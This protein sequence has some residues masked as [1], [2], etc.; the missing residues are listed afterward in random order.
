M[1]DVANLGYGLAIGIALGLT[2]GGGSIVTL[3]ILVY[4]VGESVH[5]AIT[6][7]LA[8]VGAIAAHGASLQRA[9]VRWKT[10]FVVGACGLL[11][12]FPGSLLSHRLPGNVLLSIFAAVMLLAATAMLRTRRDV[13]GSGEPRSPAAVMTAGFGLGFLT[14]FLGVGGGFLIVPVLVFVLGLSMR[15][16]IATSLFVIALNSA[17]SLAAHAVDGA[18]DGRTAVLFVLGGIGGNVV[19]L[20]VGKRL[21]QQRLKQIFATLV[22]GIGLLTGAGAVGILPF[23]VR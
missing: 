13:A 19:G 22:I 14:G 17:S 1:H 4:L 23:R 8:V 11:G 21:A 12:T 9:T 15:D 18:I 20:A 6:T 7:S 10:G 3:P 16:A 2:G 5:A